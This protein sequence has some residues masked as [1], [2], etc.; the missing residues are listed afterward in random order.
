M[1]LLNPFPSLLNKKA[2]RTK[3]TDPADGFLSDYQAND[4][5]A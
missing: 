4:G 1:S 5:A 3:D 2:A